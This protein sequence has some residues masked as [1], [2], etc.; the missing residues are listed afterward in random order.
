M[1]QKNKYNNNRTPNFKCPSCFLCSRFLTRVRPD[2]CPMLKM[3]IIFHALR[4]LSWR[5]GGALLSYLLAFVEFWLGHQAQIFCL[6]KRRIFES[7]QPSVL[8]Q[9][10]TY[11]FSSLEHS[12]KY[13]AFFLKLSF[14]FSYKNLFL[15][16]SSTFIERYEK[17]YVYN[18]FCCI[19][20]GLA[21]IP[22]VYT[23]MFKD[24][25]TKTFLAILFKIAKYWR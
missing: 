18:P 6:T 3:V 5:H 17:K 11:G 22:E 24:V 20:F 23:Q 14:Q 10:L 13:F 2:F 4:S 21:N 12:S 25:Y 9:F 8:Q 7:N 15:K 19:S 1:E 16:E